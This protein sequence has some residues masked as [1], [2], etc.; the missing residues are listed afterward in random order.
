MQEVRPLVF[1]IDE[2]P[3]SSTV[4]VAIPAPK[5]AAVSLAVQC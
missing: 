1:A 4:L 3:I 5:L 2:A